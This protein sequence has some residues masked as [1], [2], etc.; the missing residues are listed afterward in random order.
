[1]NRRLVHNAGYG[2]QNNPVKVLRIWQESSKEVLSA[3][4]WLIEVLSARLWL[5]EAKR[6]ER[7]AETDKS[8]GQST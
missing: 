5:I 1:M 6:A 4:L 8:K 7:S 3:R 2:Y